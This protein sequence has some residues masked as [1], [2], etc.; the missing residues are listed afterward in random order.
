MLHFDLLLGAF[1]PC[2]TICLFFLQFVDNYK[3]V[4][5]EKVNKVSGSILLRGGT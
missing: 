5:K 1:G 3:S 2:Y 4:V